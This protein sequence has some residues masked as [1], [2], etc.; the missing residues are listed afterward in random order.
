MTDQK[1]PRYWVNIDR[2]PVML[3]LGDCMYSPPAGRG[4]ENWWGTIPSHRD[5]H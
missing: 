5:G 2:S 1:P 4:G 3:H